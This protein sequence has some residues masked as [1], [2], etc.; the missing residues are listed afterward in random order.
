MKLL[1]HAI[2]RRQLPI[3]IFSTDVDEMVKV[4]WIFTIS[5]CFSSWIREETR[6]EEGFIFSKRG[7]S[8]WRCLATFYHQQQQRMRECIHGAIEENKWVEVE[9]K[10]T[11]LWDG[12]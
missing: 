8:S 3:S 12:S 10:V 7:W 1:H 4:A 9:T 11:I 2:Y 5:R 6:G